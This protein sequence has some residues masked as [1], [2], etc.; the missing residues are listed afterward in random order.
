MTNPTNPTNQTT[1]N[2]VP[3]NRGVTR[4]GVRL[5]TTQ[6][7]QPAARRSMLAAVKSGRIEQPLRVLVY[8]PEGVGKSTF[9][10]D[11]PS[12][13]FLGAED[14][15]AQMDVSRLPQPER[16]SEVFDAI[17]DLTE[18]KHPFETLVVDTVD[19]IEPLVWD[20][21]IAEQNNPK[22]KSIED[23]GYGKG[24]IAAVDEW[25]RFV[26]ALDRLRHARG[27]H[28]VLLGHTQ[29]RKQ[30]N[31][32]GDDWDRFTLKINERA[33][34]LLKEWCDD[35][36]FA[37]HEFYTERTRE[38]RDGKDYTAKA[39]GTG[40]R[41][42]HTSWNAAYDAKNRHSLPDQ[43]PLRWADFYALAQRATVEA[44]TSLNAELVELFAHV[45]A[46]IAAKARA[47][48]GQNPPLE[49]LQTTV[50]RLRAV[51]AET[52]A[53]DAGVPA[54]AFAPTA[55]VPTAGIGNAP[56]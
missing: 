13:V 48:L 30:K 38:S 33:G 17:A 21:V 56:T 10:S 36:L 12:P 23:F 34:G 7:Q 29:Q 18:Q 47:H 8:G 50:E 15:T 4:P 49:R 25:R 51:A 16:W 22:I 20:H 46:D 42:L 19:W 40:E 27:M 2:P 44:K 28:V 55:G 31:P 32:A 54:D 6:P 3:A 5:A 39:Q 1:T 41:L 45:P 26:T 11:A 53:R 52:I 9:G 43:I 14:G 37:R 24:Y 35:V